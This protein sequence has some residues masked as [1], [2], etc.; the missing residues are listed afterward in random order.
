[1]IKRFKRLNNSGDTI[2]EVMIV[3]AVLGLALSIA[4]ATAN[5]GL[6]Q[7]RNA[8]EHSQALGIINSQVELLRSTFA[9]QA[10]A[11]VESQGASGPFCLSPTGTVVAITPLASSGADKFE[12]VLA[13]DRLGNAT[14]Y[15]GACIQDTLYNTSIVSRG[16]GVYDF[17][18]RWEGVGSLGRQQ[19]ELT[20]KIGNVIVANTGGYTDA[21]DPPP[22][23]PAL[24][25]NLTANSSTGTITIAAGT[26]IN[27]QWSTSPSGASCT[28]S[29]NTPVGGFTGVPV[30]DHGNLAQTTS[31]ADSGR[32]YTF[33]LS[34]SLAGA[35]DSKTVTV[36]LEP[37]TPVL[38]RLYR[39]WAGDDVSDHFYDL[40]P[41]APNA[42]YTMQTSIGRVDTRQGPGEVPLYRLY[43][44][45][46]YDHFYTTSSAERDIAV[47]NGATY[48]GI[49]GYVIPFTGTCPAGT[50][51][52]YRLYSDSLTDHFYTVNWQEYGSQSDRISGASPYNRA[53]GIQACVFI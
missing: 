14:T 34:C 27:L 46:I 35:T 29:G 8:Q 19:E 11:A 30:P 7:A 1:M 18:V 13:N 49:T 42:A 33:T 5:R 53:E 52:L 44:S 41:T 39:S 21:E 20:Y 24:T 16:D 3:L 51:I 43:I 50:M 17:R 36:V 38:A 6:Q 12:E 23:A 10:G 22:S 4:Y 26:T 32:T 45:P 25:V 15:P 37:Y 47:A 48:E 2:V 28:G 31:L 40:S 9:K